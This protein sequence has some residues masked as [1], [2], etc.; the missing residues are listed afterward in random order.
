MLVGSP[1][2]ATFVVGNTEENS[3]CRLVNGS[4]PEHFL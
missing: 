2:Q 4:V 1:F 3:L